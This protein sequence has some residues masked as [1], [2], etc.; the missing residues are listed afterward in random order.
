MSTVL[1]NNSKYPL[2]ATIKLIGTFTF[3]SILLYL[4]FQYIISEDQRKLFFSVPLSNHFYS[5]LLVIPIYLIGGIEFRLLYKRI[6]NIKISTYDTISLP[7]AINFWGFIIPFQGAFIYTVSYIT[8]K[9]KKSIT[10]SVQ[11]YLLSFSISM[12]FAGLIGVCYA[13]YT[14][15]NLS[16]FFLLVCSLLLVNPLA[17]YFMSKLISSFKKGKS[18]WINWIFEKAENIFVS[19]PIDR[20]LIAYLI[21]INIINLTLNTIW[22]YYIVKSLNIDLTLIQLVLISLLMKLTLLIKLTPGNLGF[23]QLASGGIAL[24]VG[25]T[26]NA[27]FLLSTFQSL[28]VIIMAFSF[29]SVFSIINLKHFNFRKLITKNNT[30]IK[31]TI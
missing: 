1:K 11:I 3:A 25:G 12:S 21:L 13:F 8:S 22:S 23:S 5:I 15:L 20:L 28:T 9:Y 6:S 17:L 4:G 29:G 26:M 16:F 24:L 10:E 30:T 31:E 27:G 2:L 18:K 7:F 14:N 19:G